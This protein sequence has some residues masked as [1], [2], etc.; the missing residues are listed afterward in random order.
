MCKIFSIHLP[1]LINT[2]YKILLFGLAYMYE[3]TSNHH[4]PSRTMVFRISYIQGKDMNFLFRYV[5][6]DKKNHTHLNFNN[7]DL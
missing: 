6:F 3:N 4:S 5:F 7:S 1:Y 2:N